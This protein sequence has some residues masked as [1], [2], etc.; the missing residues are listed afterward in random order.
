VGVHVSSRLDGKVV[1]VTGAGQGIGEH[2][3]AA[4]AQE[5]ATVVAADIREE[6]VSAVADRITAGGGHAIAVAVDVSDE[7]STAAMAARVVEETGRID[8]LVNNAALYSGLHPGDP[9]EIPVE[10]WDRVM[11]VNLRG[12]WLCTKAVVPTMRAQRAGRIV[13]QASVAAWGG[14][15]LMHYSVSK[16]GL[17]GMT[18]SMAKL[19]G[20][21]GITVNT[22]APGQMATDWTLQILSEER[23]SQMAMAQAVHRAGEPTDL[24]GALVYLCS[25]ESSFMTGQTL[26]VDGGLVMP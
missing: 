7:G 19:L 15:S 12:P 9:F 1:I 2:Y 20:A 6:N 5:G 8:A 21:D 22:L 4:L 26:L 13:N 14:A 25:D 3:A 23:R 17:V 10:E 16:A 24:V 18:R 11:A